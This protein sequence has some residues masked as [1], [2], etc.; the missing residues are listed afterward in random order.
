MGRESKGKKV[1]SIKIPKSP[2]AG[3]KRQGLFGLLEPESLVHVGGP[4]MGIVGYFFSIWAFLF[5]FI[6]CGIAL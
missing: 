2:Q 4:L 5:L 3:R 1:Y 6:F